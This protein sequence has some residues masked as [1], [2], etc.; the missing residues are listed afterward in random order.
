MATRPGAYNQ[1]L[2]DYLF[3]SVQ[4]DYLTRG[5]DSL[6]S[7][8]FDRDLTFRDFLRDMSE[9][10]EPLAILNRLRSFWELLDKP[11]EGLTPGQQYTIDLL[12]N[13]NQLT[14]KLAVK[15]FI[16]QG[17]ALFRTSAGDFYQEEF[18]RF[19]F[20]SPGQSSLLYLTLPDT[21]FAKLGD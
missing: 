19:M 20:E 8:I 13:D 6:G 11:Q 4:T 16:S 1:T 5:A 18:D 12:A 21:P 17:P 3:P 10:P 9:V 7:N 2:V 14:F 15:P